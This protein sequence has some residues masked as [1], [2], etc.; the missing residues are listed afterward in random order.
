MKI[1]LMGTGTSQ[2]VPVIACKCPVC[3]SKDRRD[4]RLRCSALVENKNSDG[5]TTKILI[6]TG[7]EFRIQALKY[8]I[9]SLDAVLLTHGHADHIYG[10]DDIRVFSHTQSCGNGKN[11]C[12][13]ETPGKG[14]PFY[15]N[16]QT[17]KDVFHRFDYIFMETQIGGGKP[18][19]YL[20]NINKLTEENPLKIGDIEILPVPM[21]HGRLHSNGYMFST[22][23]KNEKHSILYLTDCSAIREKGFKTIR[24][25][26]GIIDHAIIDGLREEEHAT[27]FNYY[28]ALE[29]GLKINAKHIY[30][31]HITHQHT[32]T[33]IS[34]LLDAKLE[35]L[36]IKEQFYL[37]N[38]TALPGYDGLKLKI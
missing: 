8:K 31:T 16:K 21:R 37:E 15:A 2:G 13:N 11:P 30:L 33:E 5:T 3:T 28:S 38:R 35:E 32:N 4:K 34:Q 20:Q 18:K 29:T 23:K 36:G 10:L 25:K 9:D 14:L 1:T 7:P 6:D 24:E 19:I 17:L 22:F 12:K 27:H 26:G